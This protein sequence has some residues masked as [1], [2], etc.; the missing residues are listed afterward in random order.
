MSSHG[1]LAQKELDWAAP[2]RCI[3]FI[4]HRWKILVLQFW[5]TSTL[6]FFYF[7][8]IC[9]FPFLRFRLK[10]CYFGFVSTLYWWCLL[11]FNWFSFWFL[12]AGYLL[13]MVYSFSA[14]LLLVLQQ[15]VGILIS[16][17]VR[18]SDRNIQKIVHM[19]FGKPV[20]SLPSVAAAQLVLLLPQHKFT[21]CSASLSSELKYW[22]S[23]S[24]TQIIMFCA[25]EVALRCFKV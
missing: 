6:Y 20:L 17:Q 3:T 1:L 15:M 12:N 2:N 25:I 5:D 21:C 16:T 8:S 22:T 7:W 19:S 23:D 14:V 10:Y 13:L 4:Q 18:Q 9:T 11:I 24:M